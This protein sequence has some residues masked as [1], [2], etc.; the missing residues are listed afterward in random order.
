MNYDGRCTH[1]AVWEK[2]RGSTEKVWW[3]F[4]LMILFGGS[5]WAV[6]DQ[7]LYLPIAFCSVSIVPWIPNKY[8]IAS[9]SCNKGKGNTFHQA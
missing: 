3:V 9:I 5:L 2:P 1:D 4:L 8:E 7:R 6:L